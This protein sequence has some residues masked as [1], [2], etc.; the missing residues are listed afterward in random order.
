MVN[1][2]SCIRELVFL[3]ISVG[4]GS[5]LVPWKGGVPFMQDKDRALQKDLLKV[6]SHFNKQKKRVIVWYFN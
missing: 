3:L 6:M 5:F 1:E 4:F 2:R